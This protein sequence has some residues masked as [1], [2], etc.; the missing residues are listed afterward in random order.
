[1]MDFARDLDYAS[2]MQHIATLEVEDQLNALLDLVEQGEDVLITRRGKPVARLVSPKDDGA[3]A[4]A[5]RVAVGQISGK[6]LID[7]MQ[8]SPHKDVELVQPSVFFQV[9]DVEL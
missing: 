6:E 4:P 1:M 5:Q 8:R 2:A 7:L 9:R 3:A